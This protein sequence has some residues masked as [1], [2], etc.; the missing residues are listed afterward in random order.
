MNST[1]PY[2]D[3][4]IDFDDTLYDTHGNAVIALREIYEIFHLEQHF[5]HPEV[6][7]DHYWQTNV[8]L[9]E[10]Y[11]H[12]EIAREVLIVERF[13][14][15]L[16]I[17]HHWPE[18]LTEIV[19][20]QRMVSAAFC[21]EVSDRFLQLCAT[22]PGVVDGAH[23]V[24]A[25]LRRRGYR[26]HMASNGFREVQYKKLRA[27]GLADCFDTVVL[28]EDAAV[29]KPS[30]LFFDFALKA[31]GARRHSTLMIGDNPDTD[32]H[33]ARQA[34]L[35]TIFLHRKPESIRGVATDYEIH[36]LHELLRLL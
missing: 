25:Y 4:L 33:G 29:N 36:S 28:S 18:H 31:A 22:K 7:Y 2:T 34:G 5:D 14:R 20:G 8:Q 11:A 24:M 21:L 15:P 1:L 6:F 27:S 23:E 19:R 32:I 26:L 12:G 3:L 9:W 13:R 17:G 30:P 16:S 10:Q 35:P